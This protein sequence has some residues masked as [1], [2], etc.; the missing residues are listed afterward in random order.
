VAKA[1]RKYDI[2]YWPAAKRDLKKLKNNKTVLASIDKSIVA[3]ATNPRPPGA[4][5][6][7]GGT[8]YR[9]RDGEYRILYDIDDDARTVTIARIRDRKE[10]YKP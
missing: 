2:L 1:A 3:L 9:K 10:V 6:L 8:S 4:I 7:E 5:Q